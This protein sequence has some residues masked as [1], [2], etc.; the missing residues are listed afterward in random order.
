MKRPVVDLVAG[1]RPNFMKLAPV[2][3]ALL[4]DGRLRPRVVHT[5]RYAWHHQF[6]RSEQVRGHLRS[7]HRDLPRR[8]VRLAEHA[9]DDCG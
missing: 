2:L 9:D 5:G 1:A 3:R 7:S 4:A 6:L 8:R